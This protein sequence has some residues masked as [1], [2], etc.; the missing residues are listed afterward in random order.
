VL[1]VERVQHMLAL[2]RTHNI[3]K[4]NV[5]LDTESNKL[6]ATIL[7]ESGEQALAAA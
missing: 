6:V 5:Q 7:S 3:A 4:L 2:F 1:T